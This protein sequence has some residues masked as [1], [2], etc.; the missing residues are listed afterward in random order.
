MKMRAML[1]VA[2]AAGA[3]FFTIPSRATAEPVCVPDRACFVACVQELNECRQAAQKESVTCMRPCH[4]LEEARDKVCAGLGRDTR[5]CKAAQQKVQACVKEC[6]GALQEALETCVT[7][8]L[9]CIK[10]CQSDPTEPAVQ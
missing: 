1:S 3:L 9:E 10:E 8:S 2:L 6:R 5:A 7:S 4:R